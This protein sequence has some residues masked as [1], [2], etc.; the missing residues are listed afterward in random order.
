[1]IHIG[2]FILGALFMLSWI[3]I[4]VV[5]ASAIGWVNRGGG[6]FPPRT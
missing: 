5:V 2:S 1:M 3:V 4:G 6:E